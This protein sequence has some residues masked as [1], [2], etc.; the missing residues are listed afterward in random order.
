MGGKRSCETILMNIELD[1]ALG[2]KSWYGTV[3]GTERDINRDFCAWASVPGTSQ[4]LFVAE[5]LKM[6]TC[7]YICNQPHSDFMIHCS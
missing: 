2:V 5:W 4:V 7:Q 6:H 1:E 3:M